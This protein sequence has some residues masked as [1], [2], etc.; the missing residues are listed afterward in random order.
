M[1]RV[2]SARQP[3]IVSASF[4]F[5]VREFILGVSNSL[6]QHRCSLCCLSLPACSTFR[7][8]SLVCSLSLLLLLSPSF[9]FFLSSTPFRSFWCP[10]CAP[11]L[12]RFP[13]KLRRFLYLIDACA[14]RR[15]RDA[16]RCTATQT[17]QCSCFASPAFLLTRARRALSLYYICSEWNTGDGVRASILIHFRTAGLW[18]NAPRTQHLW[19]REWDETEWNGMCGLNRIEWD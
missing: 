3:L 6:M 11:R 14:L 13:S 1:L 5:L 18:R 15:A 19:L 17:V 10:S 16:M 7:P 4:V 2:I 12:A 9:P 8:S